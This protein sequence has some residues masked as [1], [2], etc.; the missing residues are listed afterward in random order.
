MSSPDPS[1]TPALWQ[2]LSETPVADCRVFKVVS[3]HARNPKTGREGEFYVIKAFNWV[4]ALARTAPGEYLMVNQYRFGSQTLS[5]EFPAG[6]LEA[7]ETPVEAATRELLEETGYKP[8]G[9]GR[10]IG[11]CYPNP[12]LQENICWV[13]LF[14]N[15]ADTGRTDWDQF[16]EMEI[17]RMP[18][19]EIVRMAGDGRIL[20]GMVH[21]AL[22]FLM[23]EQRTK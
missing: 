22:F 4:V 19:E 7:N 13:V 2:T 10:I 21:A 23:E 15:V 5:W 20:H 1:H 11:K 3:Q 8:L 6:C 18:L 9:E 17:K 16:E 14:D 12:A